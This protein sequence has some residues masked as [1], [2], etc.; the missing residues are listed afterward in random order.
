MNTLKQKIQI[1]I[2]FRMLYDSYLALFLQDAI[3]PEI[4]F[5]AGALDEFGASDFR[6]VAEQLHRQNLF[7][8]VHAPFM[9][10]SPGSPDP[11]ARALM[12]HRLEQT[13]GAVALFKP[14]TVVCHAGYDPKRYGFMR[15]AWVDNSLEMWSWFGNRVRDEGARLMLENVFEHGPEEILL[16]LEGLGPEGAGFCLDT[17]HHAAFGGDPIERWVDALTPYLGQLH[18]NDNE[19]ME[20]THLALGRGNI[21][22]HGLFKMLRARR[23]KPPIVTLEPHRQEDVWPSIRYL[24]RI[25]PW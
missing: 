7:I 12:R 18:L 2:P 11:E 24:E 17:G 15:D 19:G 4:G 6:P 16:L 1:N 21:D 14:K 22:F 20:D 3:N 23:K 9:D 5:D 10:L 25:W 13:L 8:T